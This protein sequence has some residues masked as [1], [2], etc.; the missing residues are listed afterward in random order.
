M[1]TAL[2]VLLIIA[3]ILAAVVLLYW[4]STLIT[5]RSFAAYPDQSQ[6]L[7]TMPL[8]AGLPAPVERFYRALYG[9]Q[10]PV[11]ETVVITGRARVRPAGPFYL[12][13]RFRFTHVAG[14]SYRHY[15]EATLFGIPALKINERY[16]EGESLME[17][18]FT[19][20]VANAPKNNQGANLGLWS[21]AVWFPAIY[22][23]DPRVQWQ[24]VDDV[25]ALLIVPFEDTTETFVVRFDPTTHLITYFESMRYQGAESDSKTLWLN[26]SIAWG[27][28]DGQTTLTT[29]SAI[30]MDT[31]VPWAYFTVEDIRFNVP[32]QDYIRAK[33]E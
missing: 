13:A 27:Q 22:L 20:P 33:G 32:V 15:I 3:L 16:L 6:P 2:L 1:R 18:P 24:P 11:I 21:E 5:P 7:Q 17:L 25:T 30:W 23:T 19:Q 9:D 26:K 28:L 31:G 14:Q 4:A 8:P 12:P 10:I 29:G